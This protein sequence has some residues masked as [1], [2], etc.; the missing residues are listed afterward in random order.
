MM[1]SVTARSA[2]GRG[3]RTDEASG[4]TPSRGAHS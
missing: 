4:I 1:Y 3:A 2:P